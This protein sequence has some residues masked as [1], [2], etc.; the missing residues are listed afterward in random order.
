MDSNS[1]FD[2]G[3]R[4]VGHAELVGGVEDVQSSITDLHCMASAVWKRKTRHQ[5]VGITNGLHLGVKGMGGDFPLQQHLRWEFP[6]VNFKVIV[7]ICRFPLT[8]GVLA[9]FNTSFLPC[10]YCTGQ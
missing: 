6:K 3:P 10:R 8:V 5:H 7:K 1:D 9:P 4:Q 2:L